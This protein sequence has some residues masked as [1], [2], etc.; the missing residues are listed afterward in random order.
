[1]TLCDSSSVGA[2]LYL[3]DLERL[4][5]VRVDRASR[6]RRVALSQR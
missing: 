6:H 3:S 5:W 4:G 2:T 1:M